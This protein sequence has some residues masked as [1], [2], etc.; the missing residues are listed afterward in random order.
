MN[1]K[2]TMKV[3]ATRRTSRGV[4]VTGH[5]AAGQW[6]ECWFGPDCEW[7]LG[8]RSAW[9]EVT[10]TPGAAWI[11]RAERVILVIHAEVARRAPK[12]PGAADGG[13]LPL[14]RRAPRK[15]PK[16]ARPKNQL[17]RPWALSYNPTEGYARTEGAER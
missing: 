13:P 2:I 12:P 8:L 10:G 5:D 4:L 1:L 3:A 15:A 7:L 11:D 6:R 9:V 17:A 14:A 16:A